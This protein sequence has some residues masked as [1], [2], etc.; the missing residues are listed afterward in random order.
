MRSVF[1]LLAGSVH[2]NLE[3]MTS[4][5]LIFFLSCHLLFRRAR[6]CWPWPTQWRTSPVCH[7]PLV[8]K[9]TLMRLIALQRYL[10]FFFNRFYWHTGTTVVPKLI[11]NFVTLM[12][13]L[14]SL[15]SSQFFSFVLVID[16]L[17]SNHKCIQWKKLQT[18][19][20]RLV[21]KMITRRAALI[22]N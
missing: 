22:D 12:K 1:K 19:N 4:I 8:R 6:S 21:F 20:I 17:E 2:I 5:C 18:A 3:T 10:I 14:K 13:F 16:I 11:Q 7:W 15:V 9:M